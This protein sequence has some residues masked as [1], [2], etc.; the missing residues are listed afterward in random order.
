MSETYL[1]S[2]IR[3]KKLLYGNNKWK[4]LI[5]CLFFGVILSLDHFRFW[6]IA[7]VGT[8]ERG[9][10][11]GNLTSILSFKPTNWDN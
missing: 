10:L 4:V 7:S 3:N 8:P 2:S 1:E 11:Q 9:P 5:V 6:N